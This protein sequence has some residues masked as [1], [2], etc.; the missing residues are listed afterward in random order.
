MNYNKYINSMEEINNLRKDLM[1]TKSTE[2]KTTSDIRKDDGPDKLKQLI[3]QKV[4]R[5]IN[6]KIGLVFEENFRGLLK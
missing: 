2:T 3:T 5:I 4:K 6:E 1:E